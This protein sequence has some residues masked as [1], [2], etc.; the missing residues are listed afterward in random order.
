VPASIIP[1]AADNLAN[2]RETK[3]AHG[4]TVGQCI[5][6]DTSG[7]WQL[8]RSNA[9]STL[10]TDIVAEVTSANTFRR[11]FDGE[12][13]T[14]YTGLTPGVAVG[15]SFTTA[16]AVASFDSQSGQVPSA[17]AS[18]VLGYAESATE[19]TVRKERA[20]VL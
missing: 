10:G 17:V 20:I 1:K 6:V 12:S 5:Y 19:I 4:F 3:T 7:V 9:L 18:N 13:I 16:G 15:D 11:A 14:G 2:L 8:G